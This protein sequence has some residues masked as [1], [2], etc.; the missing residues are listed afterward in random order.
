MIRAEIDKYA[1]NESLYLLQYV[2]K[3]YE[4]LRKCIKKPESKNALSSCLVDH[5]KTIACQMFTCYCYS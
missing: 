5:R 4:N 1:T 3:P 2:V